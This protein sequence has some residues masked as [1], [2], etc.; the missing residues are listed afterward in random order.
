[1]KKIVVIGG[2]TGSF[3]VLRGLK[4]YP[5]DITAVISMFDSGGST[6]MLRDEFGILPPGDV[7]RGLLALA[8]ENGDNTL[9][10]L[11]NFRF[12][13][14]CSLH[15]HSF[16]N[17]FLMAL[18][19]IT[20]SDVAAIKKAGKLLNIK[21]KVL[22]VS[23]DHAHLGAELENGHT[24]V[25]ETNIDV[26]K[27][28]GNLKI[29]R[30][31]IKPNARVYS[32]TKE[33]IEH[34]DVIVIGP[35]DLYSSVIPNLLVEGVSEALQKSR[36]IKVYVCNLMTKW[37]ETTQFAVSDHVREIVRYAGCPIDYV[38]CNNHEVK[39]KKL[40]HKYAEEKAYPVKV[41]DNELQKIGIKVIKDNVMTEPVLI[42]HDSEK[43]AKILVGL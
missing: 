30:V 35:G 42:R 43:L 37:G 32:E 6:G 17:L 13:S 36:A 24:V 3:T 40:L 23:I 9:R 25:G 15:G 22:P 41:D 4:K 26:P 28:D 10:E 12:E 39:D 2:G 1:M 19:K 11:F 20:G 33:A 8:Q 21:G 38:I 34:A 14:D 16:G 31:F 27:H 29:K 7:R 5:L 18:T